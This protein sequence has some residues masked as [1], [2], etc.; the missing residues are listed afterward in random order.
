MKKINFN[1]IF[2]SRDFFLFWLGQAVS[3]FGDLL[4]YLAL[5][6]MTYGITGKSATLGLTI[7]LQA[8]PVVLAGPF[9][10]ALID[11]WDKRKTI[12][13][14]DILRALFLIPLLIVKGRSLLYVIYA[15]SFSS[16][17]VGIFFE[18]AFAAAMPRI[19]GRK[20]ILRANSLIQTIVSIIKLIAPL[21]G[22]ALYTLLGTGI[23]IGIDSLTFIVSVITMLLIKTDL[24]TVN[25]ESISFKTVREDISSGIKYITE[26]RKI[27]IILIASL[28]FAFCSGIINVQLLPYVKNILHA[29]NQGY[30]IV[31]AVQGGGQIIGSIIIGLFVG[32]ID[33]GKLCALC[34]WGMALMVIPYTNV[35]TFG[36]LLP[37]ACLMG[38]FMSGMFICINTLIQTTADESFM[39]R[40]DNAFSILIQAGMLVTTLSSG[41]LSDR[42][43]VRPV[44]ESAIGVMIIGALIVIPLFKVKNRLPDIAEDTN[45]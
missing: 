40:V 22:T 10:G 29:G 28:F 36:A 13:T 18:P 45:N 43:G 3:I 33:K 26:R 17:L 41:I 30:G 42:Y 15:V 35:N 5:P 20:N 9:S 2:I 27:T 4:L 38:F 34:F 37:F 19:A 12:V 21:L 24:S 7:M 25:N 39:G 23:L 6:I 44:L 31:I 11:R 1:K 14:A 16:S 8:I 32:K